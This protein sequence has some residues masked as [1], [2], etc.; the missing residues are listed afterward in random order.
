MDI[1]DFLQM[2]RRLQRQMGEASGVTK[3]PYDMDPDELAQFITW[4]MTALIKELSEA[5]DELGWKPWASSRHINMVPALYEMVDAWHFFL[6]MLLAIGAWGK[7]T[8]GW[9]TAEFEQYYRE[10]NARNLQRQVE[11][12][13]GVSDKCAHCHRELPER[14]LA[15]A[16]G[17]KFSPTGV[18]KFCSERCATEYN[19]NNP[20]EKNMPTPHQEEE[21][22][23]LRR[24]ID[25]RSAQGAKVDMSGRTPEQIHEEL[26]RERSG[27]PADLDV[28]HPAAGV[29]GIAESRF[30]DPQPKLPSAP[31]HFRDPADKLE[32]G[33][34]LY[35]DSANP[36]ARRMVE[37]AEV[38]GEPLFC[39][40]ARDFF[41]VQVIT[42][43]A[44]LVEQYGPDDSEFHR[45]IIDALGDFKEWQK[46]NVAQVR[47]P[48]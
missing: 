26:Q 42:F 24:D 2:Q 37:E 19:P 48:D 15:I 23:A 16:L 10:K 7:A 27:T 21:L 33:H 13:D 28:L 43:Y 39:F 4:N 8:P 47:Y 35:P 5:T 30:L 36:H 12:Y 1:L 32:P 14:P 46:A 40:R 11:G 18:A 45:R 31:K 9:I 3:D 25:E 6:N 44:N 22:L 17:P 29:V 38:T 41:S 20:G 34:E